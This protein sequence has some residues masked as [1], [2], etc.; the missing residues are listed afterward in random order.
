M[1]F[2]YYL[3]KNPTGIPSALTDEDK[4]FA[5]NT[6]NDITFALI[7]NSLAPNGACNFKADK[8]QAT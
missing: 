1:G 4:N 7:K 8:K 3:S 6:I 2:A 5:I